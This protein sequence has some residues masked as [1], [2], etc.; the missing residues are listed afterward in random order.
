M[1]TGTGLDYVEGEVVPLGGKRAA[2]AAQA[3]QKSQ[4]V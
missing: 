4:E 1:V 2:Q 3:A